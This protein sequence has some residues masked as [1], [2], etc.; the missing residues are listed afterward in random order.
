[1]TV[2]V[3]DEPRRVVGG[4]AD[5]DEVRDVVIIGD[6]EDLAGGLLVSAESRRVLISRA[7]TRRAVTR[8]AVTR[9]AV[10]RRAV[11]GV[12]VR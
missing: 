12:D 3:D 1:M 9:R 2:E 8:R 4:V 11:T 6:A 7:V 5:A 10:T